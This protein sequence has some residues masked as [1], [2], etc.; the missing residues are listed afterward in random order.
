MLSDKHDENP[1]VFMFRTASTVNEWIP[2]IGDV[3]LKAG[4]AEINKK[5]DARS[6]R[7]MGGSEAHS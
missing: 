3:I 7:R 5:G 4:P 1:T 2:V 6:V